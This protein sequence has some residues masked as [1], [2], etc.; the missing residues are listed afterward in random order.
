MW[1]RRD[2][3]RSMACLA[4][5]AGSYGA[6]GQVRVV[7]PPPSRAVG[8]SVSVAVEN[9]AAF[10]YLPLTIAERLGYFAAEGLDVRIREFTVPGQA[11]QALLGGATPFMSGPFNTA[12]ALAARGQPH[13]CVVL[14]GRAPQVVMGLSRQSSAGPLRDLKDLRGRRVGVTALGS[15][16]HR[17]LRTLM[18]RA[19]VNTDAL[20][21]LP[22]DSP[23]SALANFRNGLIDAICYTDPVATQLEQEGLLRVVA[24]TRT[25][26]GNAQVFGGPMPSGCLMVS[27][28]YLA[29]HPGECQ[30]MVHAMVRALK[31]LQT[32]G[33]SDINRTVPE[34]FFMG[35]RGLYLAAFNRAREAWSPDGMMPA[36]G[37]A[38]A[39]RWFR[40][41]DETWA[42][43]EL[44]LASTFTNTLTLKA[45][46]RFRA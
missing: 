21:V 30:S 37:P 35:D 16:S 8:A 14:Q 18:W 33:P 24:D 41:P 5:S 12:L 32:A 7:V 31:W 27:A 25:V 43:Q 17:L 9:R 29:T 15:A 1:G 42:S 23:T 34:S 20:Q 10:C 2:W 4:L 39:L 11:V 19:G 3:T 36:D 44:D 38:T 28:S 26:Q 46:E 6:R 22:F 40:G 45:K 13:P